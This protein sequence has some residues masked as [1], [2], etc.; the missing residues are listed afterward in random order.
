MI[1]KAVYFL[2]NQVKYNRRTIVSPSIWA[3]SFTTA[4]MENVQFLQALSAMS[5]SGIGM[6]QK[7]MKILRNFFEVTRI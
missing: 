1:R 2:S 6:K 5:F 3:I 7:M 4:S